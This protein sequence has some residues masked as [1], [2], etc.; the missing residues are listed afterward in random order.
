MIFPQSTANEAQ[1]CALG[2]GTGV[3]Y[4]AADLWKQARRILTPPLRAGG[5]RDTFPA[6]KAAGRRAVTRMAPLG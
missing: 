3:S 6:I 2:W 4:Q 1:G 5:L